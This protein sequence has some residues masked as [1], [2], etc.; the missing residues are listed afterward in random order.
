VNADRLRR[1]DGETIADVDRHAALQEIKR[2]PHQGG[3]G[4]AAGGGQEF[5]R[6]VAPMIDD[7]LSYSVAEITAD[8]MSPIVDATLSERGRVW[9][10]DNQDRASG[11]AVSIRTRITT[12][13][14]HDE[15][16]RYGAPSQD[17]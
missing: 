17:A 8:A 16:Q 9:H 12:R 6:G 13:R 4:T 14:R 15:W 11:Q 1:R 2:I 10:F 7:D 5:P 3:G